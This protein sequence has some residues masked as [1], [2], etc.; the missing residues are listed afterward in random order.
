LPNALTSKPTRRITPQQAC[1]QTSN[2]AQNETRF[3]ILF[4][5]HA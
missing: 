1:S 5:A 3:S 4:C 2:P